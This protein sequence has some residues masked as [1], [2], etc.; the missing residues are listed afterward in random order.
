[1]TPAAAGL[2][3]FFGALWVGRKLTSDF[4][5]NGALVGVVA[6]VLTGGLL[7]TAKPENRLM[8]GVSYVLRILGGYLGGE[9]AQ[10][11]SKGQTHGNRIR[12]A[13]S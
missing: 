7:F 3:V 8:Y 6:V 5:T 13:E 10:R 9:V 2:A 4:G 12:E 1:V 11:L